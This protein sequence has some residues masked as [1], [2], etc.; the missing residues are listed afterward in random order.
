MTFRLPLLKGLPMCLLVLSALL[1]CCAGFAQNART[2]KG[3]VYDAQN[4]PL[5]DATV[6]VKGKGTITKT[7]KDGKFTI[8]VPVGKQVL[9]IS[10]VGK[11]T[12]EMTADN[13][14]DLVLS[15]KDAAANLEDIIV[16]GYGQQKKASVVGAISQTTGKV[17]ERTGGVSN[18][19]MALT[20]NLPGLVTTASTGMPGAETP[21]ILIRAQT[22]WN[23]SSPLIL[24][25]GVERPGALGAI[26]IASVESIS[27]LKDA[28]A[29]AVYG[30]KGANGVIL[31]TTKKGKE[32][33]ATI[34]IRSNVT[35][36][37]VSKLPAKL[38]AYDALL[39]K[40]QVIEREL[41]STPSAWTAYMPLAIID[42]YRH[43][44]NAEEWDRYPNVDWQKELFKSNTKSYNT[45]ASVSGGSK[46]VTYFAG[47]DYT[48][49]GDL[50]RTF[51]NNRGYQSGYGYSRTNVR[52]NLD[53]NLTKSTKFTTRIFGSNGVRK[54]PWGAADGDAS[55][56]ASAYR[57]SPEAMRPVYS[58]G[59]FGFYSPRNADVPNSV[60]NLAVSGLEKRTSTQL[61]TD[62]VLQQELNM[63]TK[64]LSA[65]GSISLDN[66]F[67]ET[68]RGINDLYNGPQRKWIDPG[69]G[70]VVYEQPINS[71][72]QL[73]YTDMVRWSIAA[74]SV[75]KGATYRR[76]NYMLQLNYARRFGKHDV[77]ALALLQR[78]KYA[79][80]SEFY[81]FREDWVF[82]LTY[83]YNNKY[84]LETN[85]AYNGSEKFGP[86]YRFAFFPSF[87]GGW[88]ISNESFV[89]DH[90][91]FIDQLK[92]RASWGKV[93]D[94]NVSGRWLYK[95]QWSF[96]GNAQMG[97]PIVNTPYTFYNITQLGNPNISWETVEKRNLGVEYSLLDGEIAGSVD[98]FKD[99]R[100]DVIIDGGS[101]AIPTYFGVAAPKANLGRVSGK[102]YEAELRL[103]H[104]FRGGF[105]I[106]ANTNF[107]HAVNKVIFRDDPELL[108]AY[109]QQAG[110]ALGQNRS[111]LNNGY[112][113]S[114]DD[115]YGSTQ[116][117]AN[118]NA[119]F[120]GD[121]NIVDYN[122]DGIIDNYDQAPYQYSSSPQNTYSMSIGAEWKGFSVFVQLYGVN[123]VT[124][125]VDFPTFNTYSGSNVAF[126]EGT[127]W[128]KDAGGQIPLPRYSTLMPAGGNGTR[129]LFDGSYLRLKNAEIGYT[130]S[131]KAINRLGVKT[132][133][134]YVNGNNL[135]LWTKMPDDRESNF[136]GSAAF[137][138]YPTMKRYNVGIDINL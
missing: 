35:V 99:E 57:T 18:L 67:S 72:T 41:P 85:G 63:I 51:Q 56:W 46:F 83:N 114:W 71:G 123:N 61:T 47:V 69:S 91:P 31:I 6:R 20:G 84:F 126:V 7:N 12:L 32:G 95:D 62:F 113:Q 49:E 53:F 98:V 42:K 118:N 68:G 77:S 10:H 58:D 36:K 100:R 27:I 102:G 90:L 38:D 115:I 15:L 14:E 119:K 124:R 26:D 2:I 134:L 11:S 97:S 74:G 135:A 17:L 120:A 1:C 132:C 50:F 21:Q 81:R 133:R 48:Y 103:S 111:F 92:L 87:S 106:W 138:A 24:V 109:Q 89:K 82:R 54:V 3:T 60:Y 40:N 73:D 110:W 34:R 137:G 16:V 76:L 94:D 59:T 79:T 101:R 30:V 4:Q 78:E 70:L 112:I 66:T 86:A 52:S 122:G 9:E 108:P 75:D 117:N 37:T 116:R 19:G 25:D 13:Q 128:T 129:Y 93:G 130:F 43:P 5:A 131:G 29:T 80:G 55:Y 33:K 45:S 23:N 127:Y 22:T 125:Y 65:R 88:M 104:T 64:G 121:Y 107:T 105:H 44:A 39:L 96:G 8:S 136:S 28:S